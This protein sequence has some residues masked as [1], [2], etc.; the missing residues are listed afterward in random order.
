MKVKHNEKI[1]QGGVVLGDATL[2]CSPLEVLI[3]SDAL[4]LFASSKEKADVDRRIAERMVHQLAER[5][6]E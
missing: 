1:G 2:T 3:L 5:S 4:R 6:E